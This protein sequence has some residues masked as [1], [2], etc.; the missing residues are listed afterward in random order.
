MKNLTQL[1]SISN[2]EVDVENSLV[3]FEMESEK[4]LDLVIP[5]YDSFIFN[6]H[7][8]LANCVPDFS[9]IKPSFF[10]ENNNLKSIVNKYIKISCFYKNNLGKSKSNKF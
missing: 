4:D 3:S 7:L 2:V 9:N 5:F 1:N 8:H 10:I 6:N